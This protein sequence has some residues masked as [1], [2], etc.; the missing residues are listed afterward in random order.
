MQLEHLC[1]L[2]LA[3][4]QEPLYEDVL[5]MVLPYGTLEGSLYGE[6]DA[7]FRGERL[8]G[9]ARWVN[10]AHR[11]SD[12][13]SLPDVHGVIRT[14]DGAFVLFTFQGRSLPTQDD[15]RRQLLTVCF[16]AEDERYHWL[17]TAICVLEGVISSSPTDIGKM[18]ARI[19]SCVYEL[20]T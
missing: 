17:N 14:D 11:R 6:G 12:G 20:N 19:Y 9:T 2:E 16:E 13:V 3:Y 18:R 5:K 1:D 10:H 7:T 15:K 8:S 4:R